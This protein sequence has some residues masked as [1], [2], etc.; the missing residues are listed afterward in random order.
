MNGES[1]EKWNVN[2]DQLSVVFDEK[3]YAKGFGFSYQCPCCGREGIL[4]PGRGYGFRKAGW[5][6]HLSACSAKTLK[7][8]GYKIGPYVEGIHLH[9]LVLL[10]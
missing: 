4:H 2:I 6:K 10:D 5:R 8:F 7:K 3:R 9:E 1:M